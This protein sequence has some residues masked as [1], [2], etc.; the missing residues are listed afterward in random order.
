MRHR[1]SKFCWD[2]LCLD[3]FPLGHA[4]NP[5]DVRGVS[6]ALRGE[7]IDDHRGSTDMAARHAAWL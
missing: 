1:P 5:L 6:P 4:E 2:T 7:G 3:P